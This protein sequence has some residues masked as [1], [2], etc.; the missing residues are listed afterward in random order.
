MMETIFNVIHPFFVK[1]KWNLHQKGNTFC[2]KNTSDEFIIKHLPQTNEIEIT[3]PL[4]DVAYKNTFNNYN[5]NTVSEYVKMHL[6]YYKHNR[7]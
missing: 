2:Y 5:V 7:E 1:N 6:N 4:Y 3:V